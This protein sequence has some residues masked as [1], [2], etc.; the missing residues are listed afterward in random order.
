M[1]QIPL[2]ARGTSTLRVQPEHLADRFKDAI[3][4]QVL[5][6]PVMILIMENAALNAIRPF[7][8]AGESAVGTAVDVQHSAA[9]PVGREVCASAEVVNVEG[10]RVDFNVSASDGIEEI[11]SGT[12]Q[13][14]VIDLRSFNE[15]LAKKR[16]P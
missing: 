4:P 16:L 6:T 15:R 11:G 3:L 8:D 10:K 14:I 1:R 7:L 9:T 12:H 5:A 13:R 2:G